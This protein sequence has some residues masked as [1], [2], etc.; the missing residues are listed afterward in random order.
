MSI[1]KPLIIIFAALAAAVALVACSGKD[2]TGGDA[3]NA[4]A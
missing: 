2:D 4:C 3:C 1:T